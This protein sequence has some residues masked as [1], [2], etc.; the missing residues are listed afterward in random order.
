[1]PDQQLTQPCIQSGSRRYIL[2]EL[3][4]V[5][6]SEVIPFVLCQCPELLYQAY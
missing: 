2:G 1:M 3:L 4:G 5:Q 6:L